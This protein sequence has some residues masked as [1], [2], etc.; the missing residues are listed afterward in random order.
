M[1]RKS[2]GSNGDRKGSTKMAVATEI[3]SRMIKQKDVSRKDII[4]KFMQEAKLTKAGART[5]FQL[6]KA[7]KK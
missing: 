3:Y 4:V 1:A 6:I 7:K 2:K 5:Y